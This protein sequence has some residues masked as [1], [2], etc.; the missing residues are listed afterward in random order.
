MSR[1][2]LVTHVGATLFMVGLIWFVQVVHYPLFDRVGEQGFA[3][4]ERL[5]TLRT[6][7][8]VVPPMLLEAATAV[9]LLSRRPAGVSSTQVLLGLGLLLVIWLSTAFLQVPRHQQ[10][11]AG[12]DSTVH[13]T[14]VLTNWLRTI[15]WSARGVLVLAMTARAL[16]PGP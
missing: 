13:H 14:L 12:F 10:L 4:Y 6:A 7:W 15:A 8:V 11:A 2:L 16:Q 1:Y 9:L 3:V 5:H